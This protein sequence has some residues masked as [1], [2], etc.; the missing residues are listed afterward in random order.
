MRDSCATPQA[1]CPRPRTVPGTLRLASP[2]RRFRVQKC[3]L[4]ESL[5]RT[6]GVVSTW[7]SDSVAMRLWTTTWP[8]RASGHAARM[9]P[10]AALVTLGGAARWPALAGAGVSRSALIE[11]CR[12]GT[13]LRDRSA[14]VFCLQFCLDDVRVRAMSARGQLSCSH[15][16]AAHGLDVFTTSDRVH[17]RIPQG[18]SRVRTPARTTLHAW[19]RSGRGDTTTLED[20]LRDCAH[21]LE[22]PEAVAV[23]D[24]ALRSGRLTTEHLERLASRWRGSA[25]AASRLVD[26]AAQ[27]VLE[28]V[29]RAVLVLAGVGPSR[30]RCTCLRSAGWIW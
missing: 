5:H 1:S 8:A 10:V 3:R 26:P 27:S 17:V 18:S 29:A 24:S 25:R 13:V 4:T 30:A 12:A 14:G 28:S 21:C 15:A 7:C 22:L 23:L 9:D 2:P 6:L 16:A 11:A 20:T 19:G